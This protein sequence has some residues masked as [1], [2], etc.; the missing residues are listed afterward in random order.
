MALLLLVS[1]VPTMQKV[2]AGVNTDV[3]YL[4]A[5]F[6]IVLSEDRQQVVELV[7]HYLW[8]LEGE[9]PPHPRSP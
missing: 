8:T 1:V 3:S 6:G 2:R 4:L 9:P 7:K 5:G